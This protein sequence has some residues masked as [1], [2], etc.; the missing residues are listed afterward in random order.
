MAR[1]TYMDINLF[2]LMSLNLDVPLSS[3]IDIF[4]CDIVFILVH[5]NMHWCLCI[6]RPRNQLILYY[7][8]MGRDNEE[9]IEVSYYPFCY[10]IGQ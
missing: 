9:C 6:V 10:I 7:D 1:T 5:L 2:H 4:H 3:Q 8:S